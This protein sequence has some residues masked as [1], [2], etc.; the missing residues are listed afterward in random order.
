[1]PRTFHPRMLFPQRWQ[2]R[3]TFPIKNLPLLQTARPLPQQMSSF[4]QRRT[5]HNGLQSCGPNKSNKATHHEPFHDP[6]ASSHTVFKFSISKLCSSQLP[7]NA[8]SAE[9]SPSAVNLSP[10]KH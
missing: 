4:V 5:S 1:M 10:T 8:P 9:C 2:R 6:A 7:V 3:T